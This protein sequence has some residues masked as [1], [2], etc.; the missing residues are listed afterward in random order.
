MESHCLFKILLDSLWETLEI[1]MDIISSLIS[2]K[3]V[4][5]Q[6][7]IKME[8]EEKILAWTL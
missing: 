6:K 3:V 1:S 8:G 5:Y 2:V 7:G 4:L